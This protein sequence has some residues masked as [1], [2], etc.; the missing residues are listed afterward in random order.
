MQRK[1]RAAK[2]AAT[3]FPF[4]EFLLRMHKNPALVKRYVKNPDA[5]EKQYGLTR[6]QAAAI[7][8]GNGKRVMLEVARET[9]SLF[10]IRPW[11]AP[12]QS[13]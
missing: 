9:R 1:K 3:R 13:V 10:R 8:S 7:R 4:T 2:K 12:I 11:M 6:K 5:V